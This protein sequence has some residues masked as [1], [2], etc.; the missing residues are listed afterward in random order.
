[1]GILDRWR[2]PKVEF[3]EPDRLTKAIQR[4]IDELLAEGSISRKFTEEPEDDDDQY[5]GFCGARFRSL[6]SHA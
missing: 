5:N 3:A 2:R 1:M 4:A 6:A